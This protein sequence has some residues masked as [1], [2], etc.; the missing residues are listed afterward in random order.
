M[1]V[2]SEDREHSVEALKTAYT[3]G[4]LTKEEYDA[5]LERALS[6]T[7]YADLDALVTDLPV[8]RPSIRAA[9]GLAIASLA[10]GA[11]QVIAGPLST[12]PAI[13][14]GHM[15]RK[16][17]RH[18]GEGGS[19]LALTGML[20]GYAGAALTVLALL[21]VLAVVFLFAH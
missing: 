10:C 19:G 8:A 9:N 20:L 4:R 14:L 7:T 18:S 1:R 2:S 13:V 21:T 17:I 3:D 5:R 15:A 12:V 11:G 16:Q 6:A